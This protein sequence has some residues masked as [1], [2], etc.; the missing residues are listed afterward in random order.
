VDMSL[1]IRCL[2]DVAEVRVEGGGESRQ[3]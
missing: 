2:S 3:L 1:C